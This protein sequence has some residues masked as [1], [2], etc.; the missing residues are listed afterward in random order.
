[1]FLNRKCTVGCA[2]CN[3][4]AVPG[5]DRELTPVWLEHFFKRLEEVEFSNYIIWTGGEPFLSFPTLEKGIAL[6]ESAGCGSEILTS[7]IWYPG[8]REFLY[9][10][11]KQANFSIRISLDAEHRERV[12]VEVIIELIRESLALQIEINFTLR[13]IPDREGVIDGMMM[14]IK[15]ELPEFY[16]E[17]HSR[18]RWIHKL[19]H[20]PV[21]NENVKSRRMDMKNMNIKK[22]RNQKWRQ[23]CK[24]G[25]YDL[26]IGEDGNVYPCCGLFGIEGH[27]RFSIGDPLTDSWDSMEKK[28]EQD[29]LLSLLKQRGPY[30]ICE[31]MNLK[32]GEWNWPSYESPCHLCL[33]LFHLHGDSVCRRY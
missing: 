11:E 23:A 9:R 15:K 7:G 31:E 30:G 28:Q 8:N 22:G 5:N 18:S 16:N 1:M 10:L 14:K 29:D 3:A 21:S 20:M 19:P 33:A 13:E 4:G 6:A 32:P 12:P 27:E 2:S 26:I 24:M 25:F 17:N